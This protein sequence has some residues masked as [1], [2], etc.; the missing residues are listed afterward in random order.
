MRRTEGR[1]PGS[2]PP[3]LFRKEARREDTRNWEQMN[4]ERD[5]NSQQCPLMKMTGRTFT[6]SP[7]VR[8]SPQSYTWSSS[9]AGPGSV[10]GVVHRPT[11]SPHS[12]YSTCVSSSPPRSENDR[13]PE[14]WVQGYFTEPSPTN[15]IHLKAVDSISILPGK[16]WS[17]SKLPTSKSHNGFN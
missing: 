15:A 10:F 13:T 3:M 17:G 12:L 14:G 1:D 16:A 5:M 2:S 4:W 11:Q 6:D 7:P 8:W 9:W